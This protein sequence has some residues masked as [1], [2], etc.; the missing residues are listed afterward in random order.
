MREESE[1]FPL[2]QNC[3]SFWHFF[4]SPLYDRKMIF[5]RGRCYRGM[6]KLVGR[7]YRP[8]A[9][10]ILMRF[11]KHILMCLMNNIPPQPVD[12]TTGTGLM[13]NSCNA[14]FL[15]C[16]IRGQWNCHYSEP[17]LSTLTWLPWYQG[18]FLS[19]LQSEWRHGRTSVVFNDIT[20]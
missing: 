3:V 15:Q 9:G 1:Q 11:C 14:G 19:F 2:L 7:Y 6:N 17:R 10:I 8:I 18:C 5:T 16:R 20:I 4:G 13:H 12:V